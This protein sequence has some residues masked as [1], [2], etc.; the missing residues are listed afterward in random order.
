[1]TNFVLVMKAPNYFL[2]RA[3]DDGFLK[4]FGVGGRG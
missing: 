4:G 3:P 2:H 1:M